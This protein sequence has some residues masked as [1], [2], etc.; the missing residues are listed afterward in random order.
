MRRFTGDGIAAA[1]VARNARCRSGRTGGEGVPDE[2]V[3]LTT[4]RLRPRVCLLPGVIRQR[5]RNLRAPV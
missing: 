4:T 5:A 2:R 1:R 3:L